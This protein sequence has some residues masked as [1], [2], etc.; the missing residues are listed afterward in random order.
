MSIEPGNYYFIVAPHAHAQTRAGEHPSTAITAGLKVGDPITVE[1]HD[2]PYL[3]R[4]Q[5]RYAYILSLSKRFLIP[6]FQ[7]KLIP[8]ADNTFHIESLHLPNYWLGFA[9]LKDGEPMVLW[10]EPRTFWV[11]FHP[12]PSGLGQWT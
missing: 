3:E 11:F 10:N 4:Q 7:W 5:V 6:H 2:L 1:P 9:E 8:A 12:P